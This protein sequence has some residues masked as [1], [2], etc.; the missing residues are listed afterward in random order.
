MDASALSGIYS[1]MFKLRWP[2]A[3]IPIVST[4]GQFTLADGCFATTYFS[5][6]HALHL[7]GYAGRIMLGGE[8]IDIQPGD[9]TLSPA[10]LK[11]AY[12]LVAPGKHWCV[13]FAATPLNGDMVALPLHI[14]L[15]AAANSVRE[16]MAHIAGLHA[17]GTDSPIAQAS[18]RLSLQELLLWL[19]EW[20]TAP[21]AGVGS[22]AAVMQVAAMIDADFHEPLTVPAIARAV[23]RSQGHLSRQFR[24]HFGVTIPHRLLNRRVEH[25]R[26]LLEST[27]LPIW[28]V[29]ERSG[30]PDPHH[31]N[32]TVRRLL[33]VSPSAIRRASLGAPTVDPDR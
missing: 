6:T 20:S 18:A 4:A 15:D 19:V 25:A 17:R 33:G 31:F 13:H 28:R 11:S 14:R 5:Q 3:S 16:R 32:K 9:L 12:N 23:E 30:I 21:T 26:F 27:D 2:L 29:A 8:I 7:H 1:T 22:L 24:S 10:G